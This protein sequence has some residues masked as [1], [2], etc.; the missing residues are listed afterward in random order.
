MH[1]PSDG[2]GLGV[3]LC[4]GVSEYSQLVHHTRGAQ[5]PERQPYRHLARERD[6]AQ[7]A[8]GGLGDDPDS[9][10]PPDVHASRV[11]EPAIHR[12]IEEFVVDDVIDMPVHV[13]VGPPGGAPAVYG[14]V[15]GRRT[16]IGA[17][18]QGRHRDLLAQHL[19]G[20]MLTSPIIH[21]GYNSL[22]IK[23]EGWGWARRLSRRRRWRAGRRHHV[24]SRSGDGS[25]SGRTGGR[26]S[27]APASCLV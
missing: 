6:L 7:V 2:P 14:K 24:S 13:V 5:A 20:F 4:S 3:Q 12:G 22:T 18:R 11:Y 8:A 9:W 23:L 19:T 10:K 15:T 25:R 26:R 17:A 1:E 16:S 21:G 27:S